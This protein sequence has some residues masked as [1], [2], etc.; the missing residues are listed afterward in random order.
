[1]IGGWTKSLSTELI[2]KWHIGIPITEPGA[3]KGNPFNRRAANLLE[4]HPA[5]ADPDCPW[6]HR[7]LGMILHLLKL[8]YLRCLMRLSKEVFPFEYHFDR[9]PGLP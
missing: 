4:T 5:Y 2:S 3:L 9:T 8:T 1:M 6:H 7:S